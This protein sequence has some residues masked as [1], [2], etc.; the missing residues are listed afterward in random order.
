MCTWIVPLTPALFRSQLYVLSTNCKMPNQLWGSYL[1]PWSL[2]FLNKSDMQPQEIMPWFHVAI[3][4]AGR[5]FCPKSLGKSA[6]LLV[7]LYSPIRWTSSPRIKT[8]SLILYSF[9]FVH[10][11]CTR[12]GFDPQVGKIPWRRERLPIPVFWPGESHGLYSQSMGSQ[13]RT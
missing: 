9:T 2:I 12:P 1:L 3:S 11:Q 7:K 8:L 5:K 6:L 4:N 13:S 10:R